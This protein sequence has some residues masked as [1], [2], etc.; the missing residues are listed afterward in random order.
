M[1]LGTSSDVLGE[2]VEEDADYLGALYNDEGP[3]NDHADFMAATGQIMQN[4]QVTSIF[5][6]PR[7]W[8]A[9][10]LPGARGAERRGLLNFMSQLIPFWKGDTIRDSPFAT[11]V[12][13]R[14]WNDYINNM[15]ATDDAVELAAPHSQAE[16]ISL[17][18]F[19]EEWANDPGHTAFRRRLMQHPMVTAS[20]AVMKG[21][22]IYSLAVGEL[23]LRSI[24]P[25][26]PNKLPYRLM[27]DILKSIP[28]DS[29]SYYELNNVHTDEGH[30]VYTDF[31]NRYTPLTATEV[32][33]VEE[34]RAGVTGA[35][36]GFASM[37]TNV[38]GDPV[39]AYA[40]M[41][42]T[43]EAYEVGDTMSVRANI[44]SLMSPPYN[45]RSAAAQVNITGPAGGNF[46]SPSQISYLRFVNNGK[47]QTGQ[48]HPSHQKA[49]GDMH[50]I[51]RTYLKADGT[52]D[53]WDGSKGSLGNESA[54]G[55]YIQMS[56]NGLFVQQVWENII[57]G[58]ESGKVWRPVDE[59]AYSR[60]VGGF[61]QAIATGRE[62]ADSSDTRAD[63]GDGPERG[64]RGVRGGSGGS[65]QNPGVKENFGKPKFSFDGPG[66]VIT[67][68]ADTATLDPRDML[69]YSLVF[70]SSTKTLPWLKK[71]K[72]DLLNELMADGS[73]TFDL[74]KGVTKALKKGGAQFEAMSKAMQEAGYKFQEYLSVARFMLFSHKGTVMNKDD[75]Q[76]MWKEGVE[77]LD[78]VYPR[79]NPYKTTKLVF[80]KT[81]ENPS[82]RFGAGSTLGRG[83]YFYIQILPETQVE[84]KGKAKTGKGK[85]AD[86]KQKKGG[87]RVT[88]PTGFGKILPGSIG[89]GYYIKT[90]IHK[91]TG[92]E[93]PWLIALPRE[94]FK[95]FT[96]STKGGSKG[97][98]T[99]KPFKASESVKKAW[100][101][102]TKY[103]GH[104]VFAGTEGNPNFFRI[105][106]DH[107]GEYYD[108]L[109]SK[110]T[111]KE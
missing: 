80:D 53:T 61:V 105:H 50:V 17:M 29:Y 32:A 28:F 70:A 25:N 82:G 52:R 34:M 45:Y 101:K 68:V 3:D 47:P 86:S 64:R 22:L 26:A 24:P 62:R 78:K 7:G 57:T 97:L 1:V 102:F 39:E 23:R 55:Y 59:N 19:C 88:D 76:K 65:R 72:D 63:R 106:R 104:P 36:R 43:V 27:L 90:G 8:R 81:Y 18:L 67:A 9:L 85:R 11:M 79:K 37:T 95:T 108:K 93:E 44:N 84:F 96:D 14:M 74:S 73:I 6:S 66:K 31:L 21:N 107:K 92:T 20:D 83:K 15:T 12:P 98:R 91:R 51:L 75:M 4:P 41:R 100:K 111:K 69:I 2:A 16:E 56:Q 42:H 40:L 109:R 49:G 71:H 33:M 103:Y 30:Q 87:T 35:G 58:G 77:K 10:R 5:A 89:K 38:N 60:V 99:I 94:H 46:V 110:P 13:A 54:Q 48:N